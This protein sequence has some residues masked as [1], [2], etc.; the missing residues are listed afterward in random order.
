MYLEREKRLWELF[1]V[2]FKIGMFTFGGG[3]AMISMIE[4]EVG[5]KRG[6]IS[7]EELLEL[8]AIAESTPGPIAINSATYIGYRRAGP[9]G[10]ACATLGVVLPS[11][12]II[13]VISLF[14]E[15]F[16]ALTIVANAFRGIEAA[17]AF[18][19]LRAGIRMVRSQKK[20]AMEIAL[21]LTAGFCMLG[22]NLFGLRFSTVYIILFG[23]FCGILVRRIIGRAG[24][25]G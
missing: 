19:I 7:Q 9:S 2:F 17:V 22:I 11:F 14:I 4:N 6:W 5:E 24:E 13:Y 25:R 21:M 8:F 16:M 3:Y 10:S 20:G 12:I 23:A 18:L 15:R 1:S